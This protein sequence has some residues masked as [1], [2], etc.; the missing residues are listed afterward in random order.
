MKKVTIKQAI[1]VN[2]MLDKMH[3]FKWTEERE[4]FTRSSLLIEKEHE[5]G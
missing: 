1:K 4:K 5:I 2:R 3:R